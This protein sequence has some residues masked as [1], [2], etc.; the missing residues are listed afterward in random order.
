MNLRATCD[1]CQ[2]QIEK[3]EKRID[4]RVDGASIS[5]CSVECMI[6][7]AV[8]LYDMSD[9][10]GTL[11]QDVEEKPSAEYYYR[12]ESERRG[13]TG[14]EAQAI[15]DQMDRERDQSVAWDIETPTPTFDNTPGTPITFGGVTVQGDN[16]FNP[17]QWTIVG[18]DQADG[19]RGGTWAGIERSTAPMF[20]STVTGNTGSFRLTNDENRDT[21]TDTPTTND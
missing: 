20:S 21:V 12:Q 10:E 8:E 1:K 18:R 14:A 4:I 13:M 6:D 11:K 17:N 15:L 7:W 5:I 3:G 19:L 2:G 9:Q 16:A